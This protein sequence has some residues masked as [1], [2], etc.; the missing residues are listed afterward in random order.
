MNID[1][2]IK[3]YIA[4]FKIMTIFTLI[5]VIMIN[6]DWL[7]RDKILHIICL[8]VFIIYFIKEFMRIK[9][10]LMKEN[11]KRI[12]LVDI[13]SDFFLLSSLSFFIIINQFSDIAHLVK[14]AVYMY[15]VL[16]I[17][18]AIQYI[19]YSKDGGFFLG[20][21][22]LVF[23][24]GI[25]DEKSQMLLSFITTIIATLYGKFILEIFFYDQIKKCQDNEKMNREVLLGV[26]E[27][28]LAMINISIIFAQIIVI[29]TAGLKNLNFY[30]TLPSFQKFAMIGFI[31]F[32][33]LS[34]VQFL[35]LSKCGKKLKD[36]L[37]KT[38]VRME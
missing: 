25:I 22:F 5:E 8:I 10:N 14:I 9:W 34:A 33:I 36:M 17:I 13:L 37:F 35:L 2:K 18:R 30:K 26:L 6:S 27:Y 16:Y 11:P 31:R 24:L 21:L 20:Y 32:I 23:I 29:M 7:C 3:K 38:L 4:L 1:T 15:F 12:Y 19:K 28:R